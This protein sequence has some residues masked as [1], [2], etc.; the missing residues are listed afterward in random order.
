MLTLSDLVSLVSR[1]VG[2][3]CQFVRCYQA[4]EGDLRV[5]VRDSDI[6]TMQRRFTIEGLEEGAP[7]LR[8]M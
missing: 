7:R 5:I 3:E 1:D 4:I 2:P 6:P 8:E